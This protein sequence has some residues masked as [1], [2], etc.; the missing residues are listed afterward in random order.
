[1]VES[2]DKLFKQFI[3][4]SYMAEIPAICLI[5]YCLLEP[6]QTAKTLTTGVFWMLY[7]TAKTVIISV[8]AI[9]VNTQVIGTQGGSNFDN[10]SPSSSMTFLICG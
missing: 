6:G 8:A 5:M 3:A 9:A 7:L 2:V 1:M 10:C 4:N